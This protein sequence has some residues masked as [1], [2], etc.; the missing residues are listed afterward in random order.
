MVLPCTSMAQKPDI[1]PPLVASDSDVI[2]LKGKV[3][4][5][6]MLEIQT[7]WGIF[8]KAKGLRPLRDGPSATSSHLVMDIVFYTA[9]L[10]IEHAQNHA[11]YD[12]SSDAAPLVEQLFC[13]LGRSF[14][15]SL[16]EAERRR[17]KEKKFSR[18]KGLVGEPSA[19]VW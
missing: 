8:G 1:M 17:K 14:Y 11:V 13:S 15:S 5:T 6:I 12:A 16:D 18:D 19:S 4:E 3:V 9:M 7:P 2:C 10:S